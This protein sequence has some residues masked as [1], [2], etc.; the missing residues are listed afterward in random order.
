M[1]WQTH[2]VL[3]YLC[4][5][6][7]HWLRTP[8]TGVEVWKIGTL[9]NCADLLTK[10][11]DETTLTRPLWDVGIPKWDSLEVAAL[12]KHGEKRATAHVRGH[13]SVFVAVAMVQAAKGDWE[14]DVAPWSWQ[15]TLLGMLFYMSYFGCIVCCWEFLKYL[16]RR[17]VLHVGL[18]PARPTTKTKGTMTD[19]E[20]PAA[21]PVPAAAVP[22]PAAAPA[23]VTNGT[24][25]F[26]KVGEKYHTRV[27]CGHVIGRTT[28]R[29]LKCMDCTR[30][31]D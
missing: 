22:V 27:N 3:A 13:L 21:A 20:Q 31:D 5:E 26:T 15:T 2:V 4:S 12:V 19:V 24:I 8:A 16:G 30:L 18:G 28:T 11:V 1:G 6:L 29:Y 25:M 14:E 17:A 7:A 10:A 9:V 23:R